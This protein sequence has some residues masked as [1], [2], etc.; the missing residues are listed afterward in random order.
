MPIGSVDAARLATLAALTDEQLGISEEDVKIRFAVPLLEA[1]GHTRLRFEHKGKD[2]LLRDGLPRG[3]TV[4]VET[5]RP[6]AALDAHLAQLDTH[7]RAEIRDFFQRNNW[8]LVPS[9]EFG[10]VLPQASED[11]AARPPVRH[12]RKPMGP[13][14][15][16]EDFRQNATTYQQRI[17]A[18]F[19]RLGRRSVG[20]KQIAKEVGLSAQTVAAALA[21][22]T[23][24]AARWGRQTLFEVQKG[25]AYER[26]R[27]G[28]V[29]TIVQRHWPTIQRLYRDVAPRK[30]TK[31][32][33]TD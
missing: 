7:E 26:L 12:W 10:Y 17:L 32:P 24:L 2:I 5:K 13:E 30:R 28:R 33:S 25:S 22:F 9:G 14:W 19:V 18:G 29:Y 3:S 1:L 11:Q 8:P 23:R 21:G 4:V 31:K 16:D 20:I 27:Q 15:T 6:D